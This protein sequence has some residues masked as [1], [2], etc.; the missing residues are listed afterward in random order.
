MHAKSL[1]SCPTLCTPT[2]CS[3]CTWDFPGKNT[4]MGF[5]VLL[6]GKDLI[7]RVSF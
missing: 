3:L 4:G 7:L 5:H 2:D 6:W 1:Q